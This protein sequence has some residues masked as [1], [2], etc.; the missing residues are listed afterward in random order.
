MSQSSLQSGSKIF[1]FGSQFFGC[2]RVLDVSIQCIPEDQSPIHRAFFV[3]L[4]HSAVTFQSDFVVASEYPRCIQHVF[5]FF[6]QF[7]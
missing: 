3:D 6:G 1:E 5:R 4:F 2:I 7:M